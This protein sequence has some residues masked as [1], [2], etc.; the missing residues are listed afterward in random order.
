MKKGPTP[1]LDAGPSETLRFLVL[2]I[3]ATASIWD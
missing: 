2:T 1:K 3:V